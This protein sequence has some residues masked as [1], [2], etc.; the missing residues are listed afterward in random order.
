MAQKDFN[1]SR[2]KII[3]PEEVQWNPLEVIMYHIQSKENF[4][5]QTFIINK[6]N[7]IF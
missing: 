1:L 2:A 4:S 3:H 6:E 5:L 7:L